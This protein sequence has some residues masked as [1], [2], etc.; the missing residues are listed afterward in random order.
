M[1]IYSCSC[2][3]LDWKCSGIAMSLDRAPNFLVTT[4]P[5]P[6]QKCYLS[7]HENVSRT[8]ETSTFFPAHLSKSP[9][10]RSI[11]SQG[12]VSCM[13]STPAPQEIDEPSLNSRL[14]V[15]MLRR[16]L[17]AAG[18]LQSYAVMS[19]VADWECASR[20]SDDI[21]ED[22]SESGGYYSPKELSKAVSLVQLYKWASTGI[23]VQDNHRHSGI[24]SATD[25]TLG[26]SAEIKH[27]FAGVRCSLFH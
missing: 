23:D 2:D 25:P 1:A 24:C 7:F 21:C 15:R 5:I 12:K 4:L 14:Q 19:Y 13:D 6:Q 27:H 18:T 22:I 20:F 11:G 26:M 16:F 9:R 17:S 8:A 3:L 10:Y